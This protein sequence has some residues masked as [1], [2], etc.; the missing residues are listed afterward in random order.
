MKQKEVEVMELQ[1]IRKTEIKLLVLPSQA[2]QH[3][4]TERS[5]LNIALDNLMKISQL[6]CRLYSFIQMHCQHLV[7]LRKRGTK[8]Q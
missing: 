4:N 7:L 5:E 2:S 1:G 6:I 3:S 8:S